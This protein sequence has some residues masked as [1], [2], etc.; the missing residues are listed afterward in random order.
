MNFVLERNLYYTD[1][2]QQSATMTMV[3]IL[4]LPKTA[5]SYR[6]KLRCALSII[7]TTLINIPSLSDK[8]N[9]GKAKAAST[10]ELILARTIS[11]KPTSLSSTWW[12]II[13]FILF[14]RM[15]LV[16]KCLSRSLL[17]V[18]DVYIKE[19]TNPQNQNMK[20]IAMLGT[21]F[22]EHFGAIYE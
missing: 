8:C 19:K 5:S 10:L 12:S 22:P 21:F 14:Q 16:V 11:A 17:P 2:S 1:L 20:S 6:S 3:R 15:K 18:S 4:S 7:K 9:S 13:P